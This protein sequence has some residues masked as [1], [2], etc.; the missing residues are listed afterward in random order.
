MWHEESDDDLDVQGDDVFDD[1]PLAPIGRVRRLSSPIWGGTS[2]KEHEMENTRNMP[3]KPASTH[4]INL[5][6]VSNLND[7]LPIPGPSS[8]NKPEKSK[9][10]RSTGNKKKNRCMQTNM[11]AKFQSMANAIR[12]IG[13]KDNTPVNSPL[14]SPHT[15]PRNSP[16]QSMLVLSESRTRRNT[17]YSLPHTPGK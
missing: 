8:L 7:I 10:K 13:S 3:K 15:T 5:H 1:V 6:E 17:V 12:S 2:S 9:Q 16:K 14:A 11:K 4:L